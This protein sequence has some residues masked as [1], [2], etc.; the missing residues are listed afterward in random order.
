MDD[1]DIVDARPATEL[2]IPGTGET[3]DLAIPADAARAV[4][5]IREY[6]EQLDVVKTYAKDRLI[7]ASREQGAKT[8]RFG[9]IVVEIS[10][11]P[12]ATGIDCD[13]LR[14]ELE[15]AGCPEERINE[16]IKEEIAYKANRSVCRQLASANPA[17]KAA[18][19]A[20]TY[21]Y[22]QRYGVR[23]S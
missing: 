17:Y 2:V 19:E 9:D 5:A 11:G 4:Q 3:F 7:D 6:E 8:L 20:A 16:A 1:I 14:R 10:G 21:T 18:V 15:K 13:I 23:V 22:E 12:G